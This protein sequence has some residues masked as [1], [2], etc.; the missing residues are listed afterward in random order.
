MVA[1]KT[2]QSLSLSLN[3]QT[4]GKARVFNHE[5]IDGIRTWSIFLLSIRKVYKAQINIL[6]YLKMLCVGQQKLT[7]FKCLLIVQAFVS[8]NRT[9][10]LKTDWCV[11][12]YRPV[13]LSAFCTFCQIAK[14]IKGQLCNSNNHCVLFAG[15]MHKSKL[16]DPI[17]GHY[18]NTQGSIVWWSSCEVGYATLHKCTTTTTPTANSLLRD[19]LACFFCLTI[20][21]SK[22]IALLHICI[23]LRNWELPQ[24][25]LLLQNK[26]ERWYYGNRR[27]ANWRI[28]GAINLKWSFS[29]F[30]PHNNSFLFIYQILL[31]TTYIYPYIFC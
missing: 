23:S 31:A 8:F 25:T 2:T 9:I 15:I 26:S 4:K 29:L 27:R 14:T 11:L 20:I 5:T 10:L 3:R 17:L 28:G 16:E 19:L 24:V 1:F 6:Q 7:I 30:H 13:H 21:F 18:K 22:L 12:F